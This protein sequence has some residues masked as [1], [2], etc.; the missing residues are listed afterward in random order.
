MNIEREKERD[1]DY[2][3][4]FC[5]YTVNRMEMRRGTKRWERLVSDFRLGQSGQ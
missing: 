4:E 1:I 2:E 5:A 3:F